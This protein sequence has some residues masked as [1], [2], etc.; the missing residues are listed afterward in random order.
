M[1]DSYLSSNSQSSVDS[2]PSSI[3]SFHAVQLQLLAF[4]KDQRKDMEKSPN[5]QERK[6]NSNQG[7][8][9][10]YSRKKRKSVKTKESETKDRIN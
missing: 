1:S 5:P 10:M 7:S 6:E 4:E 9:A 8:I 2:A 3:Q